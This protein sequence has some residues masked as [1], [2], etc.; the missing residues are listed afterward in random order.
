MVSKAG[1]AE[2][3]RSPAFFT[4]LAALVLEVV[5]VTIVNTVLPAIGR[6]LHLSDAQAQWIVAGYSLSFAILLILGG[7]LGDMFG[8][9]RMFLLGVGGFTIASI[10]CGIA[11]SSDLLV[12]ARIGQGVAGALM[13][14][15][16]MTMIQLLYDPVERIGRMAWFG[17]VGGMAAIAGPLLGGVIVALNLFGLGWR[18][19]FLLN[20]PIGLAAIGAGLFLL[21]STQRQPG[22]RV[23]ILGTLLFGGS[24]FALLFPIIEE[25]HRGLDWRV[26]GWWGAGV[27]L[28]ALGWG[29]LHRRHRDGRPTI[30]IPAIFRNP[31]FT[32]GLGI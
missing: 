16:V 30:V 18:L 12:A 21:P 32:L 28:V 13:A 10:L 15:Q 8:G 6:D 24:L 25:R 11:G 29:D 7:R 17:V 14:P 31:I 2:R 1:L 26:A 23:D 3:Q 19:V 22:W 27:V 20:V 5:D 9:R 4:L